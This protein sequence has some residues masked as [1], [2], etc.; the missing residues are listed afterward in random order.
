MKLASVASLP[1]REE[2]SEAAGPSPSGSGEALRSILSFLSVLLRTSAR[3]MGT[4][5]AA[6]RP[7][8]TASTYSV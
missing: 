3:P 7:R 8:A 6:G 2:S 1:L 4:M 5:E